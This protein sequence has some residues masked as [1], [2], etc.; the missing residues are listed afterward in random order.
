LLLSRRLKKS[1][2]AV[3]KVALFMLVMRYV[4]L[5]WLILPSRHQTG[6]YF[7]WLYVAT[8]LALGGLWLAFFIQQLK[9]RLK[10]APEDRYME[11]L[12]EGAATT[13]H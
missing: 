5:G 12:L 9:G 7:H 8:P 1:A 10:L 6:F 11:R 2:S 4:D 3:G 13:G